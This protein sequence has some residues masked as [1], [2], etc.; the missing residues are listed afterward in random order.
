LAL[1]DTVIPIFNKTLAS[2]KKNYPTNPMDANTSIQHRNFYFFGKSFGNAGK[3]YL[4]TARKAGKL[5]NARVQ[6][7]KHIFKF[8]VARSLHQKP[9]IHDK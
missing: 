8:Q 3:P 5:G 6:L 9:N 2:I 1:V 4:I 7:N